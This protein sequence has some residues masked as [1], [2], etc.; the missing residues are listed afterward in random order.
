MFANIC[1]FNKNF[2]Q[3]NCCFLL[4]SVLKSLSPILQNYFEKECFQAVFQ[5]FSRFHEPI[6]FDMGTKTFTCTMTLTQAYKVE[7]ETVDCFI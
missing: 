1:H 4:I 6:G 2:S 3:A 5:L 7:S